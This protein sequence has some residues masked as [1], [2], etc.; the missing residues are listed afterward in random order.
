[1]L[2]AQVS[3]SLSDSSIST[4]VRIPTFSLKF[5][6]GIMFSPDSV[7]VVLVKSSHLLMLR[8]RK[9][10]STLTPLGGTRQGKSSAHAGARSVVQL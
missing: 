4:N 1:M 8:V 9:E 5:T 2:S 7:L 3:V 10:V 6:L